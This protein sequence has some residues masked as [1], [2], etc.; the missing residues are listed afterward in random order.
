M[1]KIKRD[2]LKEDASEINQYRKNNYLVKQPPI[3]V[4]NGFA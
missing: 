4:S 3:C 1:L 2:R